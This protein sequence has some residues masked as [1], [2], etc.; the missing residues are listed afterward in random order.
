MAAVIRQTQTVGTNNITDPMS[1]HP[2]EYGADGQKI[3]GPKRINVTAKGSSRA[4]QKV[5]RVEK[6][7]ELTTINRKQRGNTIHR[8]G[9]LI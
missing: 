8:I 2:G 7:A 3:S 1:A 6:Y 4:M 9:I 5:A